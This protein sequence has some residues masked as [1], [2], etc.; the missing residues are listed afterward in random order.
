MT[1]WGAM[2][3]ARLLDFGSAADLGIGIAQR[4]LGLKFDKEK[5]STHTKDLEKVTHQNWWWLNGEL[6]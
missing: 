5:A 3:F 6:Q 2:P 4:S 1:S